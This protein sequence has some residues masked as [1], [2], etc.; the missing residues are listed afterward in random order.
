MNIALDMILLVVLIISLIVGIYRG[1]IKSAARFLGSIIAVCVSAL[2]GGVIATWLFDTFFRDSFTE[3][4]NASITGMTGQENL[5]GLFDS[6]PEF[7]QRALE[8]AGISQQSIEGSLT[9]TQGEVAE[10]LVDAAAPVFILFLK[11]LA[12]IVLFMVC[13]IIVSAVAALLDKLITLPILGGVN[14]ALGGLFGI[15]SAVILLWVILAA[16]DVFLPM[17]TL[18]M[19][20]SVK[21]ALEASCLTKLLYGFNPIRSAF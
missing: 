5:T 18:E 13:M 15:L 2:F 1:L 20:N 6:L 8:S 21:D 14:K 12:V 9:Q 11:V 16:V 17:T 10:A 4:I 7:I 19:Q 3:K